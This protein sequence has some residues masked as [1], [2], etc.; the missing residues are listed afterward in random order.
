MENEEVGDAGWHA[1]GDGPTNER[2]NARTHAKMDFACLLCAR[3][4]TDTAHRLS[5]LFLSSSS[6]MAHVN[7]SL[8]LPSPSFSKHALLAN[9]TAFPISCGQVN[10]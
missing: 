9:I 10:L 6:T 2:T 1:K 3:I 8:L 4:K 5:A 7:S